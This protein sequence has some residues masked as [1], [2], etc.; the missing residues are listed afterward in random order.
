MNFQLAAGL[1]RSVDKADVAVFDQAAKILIVG[2]QKNGDAADFDRRT[3]LPGVGR[4]DNSR[5]GKT[6]RH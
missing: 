1:G 3:R 6:G 5:S 2:L 4:V